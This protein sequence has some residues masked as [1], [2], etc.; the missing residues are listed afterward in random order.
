MI[1]KV[2]PPKKM[3]NEKHSYA[4]VNTVHAGL[5]MVDI[6]WFFNKQINGL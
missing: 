6:F 4:K 1:I 2:H 3:N 5:E